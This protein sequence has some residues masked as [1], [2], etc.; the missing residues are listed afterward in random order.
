MGKKAWTPGV[1]RDKNVFVFQDLLQEVDQGISK[2]LASLWFYLVAFCE[3]IN[4]LP[5]V[6]SWIAVWGI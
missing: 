3:L 2:L 4:S 1:G 5:E 6:L